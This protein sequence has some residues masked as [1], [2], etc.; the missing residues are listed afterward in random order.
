V[1]ATSLIDFD[2]LLAS[3]GLPDASPPPV[4]DMLLSNRS[5]TP[6]LA[7][8]VLPNLPDLADV[9][10]P[11]DP[12]AAFEHALRAFDERP[13]AGHAAPDAS[14]AAVEVP[15]DRTNERVV[16]ELEAWLRVLNA[17]AASSTA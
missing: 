7:D 13:A 15:F 1:P 3:L 9:S 2:A 17:P 8:P 10:A 6:G 11:G 12:F 16:N 4:M 14:S 5:S